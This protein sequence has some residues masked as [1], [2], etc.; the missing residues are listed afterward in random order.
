MLDGYSFDLP[1]SE[2]RDRA[3]VYRMGVICVHQLDVVLI[4]NPSDAYQI[5]QL[6]CT[7][8]YGKLAK[9]SRLDSLCKR[10]VGVGKPNDLMS[11]FDQTAS[12]RPN[13]LLSTTP[14][15]L[16]GHQRN[17]QFSAIHGN[18]SALCL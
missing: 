14:N 4:A 1:L 13:K 15:G 6:R 16:G 10:A 8:G 7:A 9:S 2:E 11:A 12:K 5:T 17:F 3:P 18:D